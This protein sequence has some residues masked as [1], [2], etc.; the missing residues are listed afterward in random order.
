MDWLKVAVELEGFAQSQP[1]LLDTGQ[2]ASLAELARRIR[3]GQRAVLLADEVGMGKTRIAIAL[4]EAVRQAGGRSAIIV[5]AGLGA[6]WQ[7]ELRLFNPDNATLLP[8]RSYDGFIGGFLDVDDA[9]GSNRRKR[10]HK[11]WLM[12]RRQQRELPEHGWAAE[13]IL[14]ISHTFA[15]MRFPN[16]GEGPAGGWRR[17]LLPNVARL[18]AGRRRNFIRENFRPGEVGQ[19]YASRRAAHAI[20]EAIKAHGLDYDLDG[21]P[22]WLSA[23]DYKRKILPLI[24]YGLGRFDLVVVDEAHKARGADSSLSRILGPVTWEGNDPFR[25]GLTATPVELDAAQWIDTLGRISGRDDERDVAALGGLWEWIRGYV[26]DV[27]RAQTEE[28]DEQLT[29][30]FESSAARFR[31]ALRPFV[32]RRDK[33]DDPEYRAFRDRH[34][35]YRVVTDVPVLPETEGFT[36]DWLRRFCAAEALSLLPQDDPRIKRARLSVAQGYGFGLA[37]DDEAEAPLPPDDAESR[38]SVWLD[39]FERQPADLYSHPAILAA[40]RLIED[41]TGKGEKVL[42]FG[43]FIKPL[44]AL[45]RLLDARE[46]LRRLEKGHHWPASSVRKENIPAVQAATRD[47]GLWT[48]DGEIAG[49]NALLAERY[50]AWTSQRRTDLTRLRHDLA[51]MQTNP[52]AVR[53]LSLLQHD[54]GDDLQ[55]DI[56]TLL[57]A[58]ADLRDSPHDQSWTAEEAVKRF[59]A[60]QALLMGDDEADGDEA[61]QARLETHLRDYSGR[62]GNFARMMWGATAPQTRRLLQASFNRAATWPMVLLAQSRVG[63]EGLNLHEA[64]RTVVLLHAEWNPGIVEQQIGRVDRKNSR[65]LRDLRDW[66]NRGGG[67]DPPRIRIHP[68]V[69][70]GTYDDHNWQVLKARWL[71][72]RAQLHGDVLPHLAGRPAATPEKQELVER[73]LRAT[74]NF[75][76]PSIG[77]ASEAFSAAMPSGATQSGARS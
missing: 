75:A 14:M 72:L 38:H 43:R 54:A 51:N 63:R 40:V 42:V 77:G 31:D 4:I 65:W 9:E 46:M 23:D 47:P 41:Y 10:S 21:D 34:G 24:G 60:L 74:P 68:V 64:C 57:E 2:R 55:G 56:G 29:T 32:L 66:Q 18:V 17:E 73:I 62:E 76:P 58:L 12:D 33:R 44:G 69:V 52:S 19:V 48:K 20:A 36:R 13:P 35:D 7:A 1:E 67:G 61:L 11:K 45:T 71:E 16:R 22:K 25:L 50:R 37:S 30:G 27:R 5:P 15:A 8:L 3:A 53:L 59:N 49:I 70:S 39:A 26:D 6:Q 28:L